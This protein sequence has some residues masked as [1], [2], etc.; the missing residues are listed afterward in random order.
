MKDRWLDDVK[1]KVS[2]FE[3]T[4]PV[5]FDELMEAGSGKHGVLPGKPEK[6]WTWKKISSIAAAFLLAMGLTAYLGIIGN[7]DL[8]VD[9][10]PAV[11]DAAAPDTY[12][13][14]EPARQPLQSNLRSLPEENSSALYA[15]NTSSENTSYSR[16]GSGNKLPASDLSEMPGGD[17]APD[18]SSKAATSGSSANTAAPVDSG[19]EDTSAPS[20]NNVVPDYSDS[21]VFNVSHGCN[22]S[23]IAVAASYSAIGADERK[24]GNGGFGRGPIMN[25]GNDAS[26]LTRM[27]GLSINEFD[28]PKNAQSGFFHHKLPVKVGMG[29]SWRLSRLVAVETGLSYSYLKSDITYGGFPKRHASQSLHYVGIPVGVR[30][31]PLSWNNLNLYVSAGVMTEKCVAGKLTDSGDYNRHHFDYEGASDR[32]WQFSVNAGVGIQY[33][34]T[35]S[36]G[37]FVQPGVS[38]YFDDGSHLRNA[39]SDHPCNFELNLGFRFTI[40]RNN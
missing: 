30:L 32:P 19:K 37:V 23:K 29:V 13:S 11:A 3:M 18:D 5:S 38:Y 14:E 2:D 40:P 35:R 6:R 24:S 21:E 28:L 17:V 22:R 4:P 12:P 8:K 27:G 34:I 9:D 16:S 33:D 20:D 31:I 7:D 10:V 15:E 25:H 26:G 1:N 36:L 39:Y